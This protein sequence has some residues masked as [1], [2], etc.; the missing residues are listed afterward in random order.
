MTESNRTT[1]PVTLPRWKLTNYCRKE[2]NPIG[3]MNGGHFERH[4]GGPWMLVSDVLPLL[5]ELQRLRSPGG[6]GTEP[7]WLRKELADLREHLRDTIGND[8]ARMVEDIE[9]RLS[10][11][12]SEIQ[13]DDHPTPKTGTCGHPALFTWNYLGYKRVAEC[14]YCSRDLAKRHLSEVATELR[15]TRAASSGEPCGEWQSIETAPDEDAL[16]LC[17]GFPVDTK[18]YGTSRWH[19]VAVYR[20]GQFFDDNDGEL[21][22]DPTHW[23]PCP[24]L[25]KSEKP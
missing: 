4:A 23:M 5:E 1:D 7:G 9:R 24:T 16:V 13:G 20:D 18:N 15:D 22:A 10:G 2:C 6:A 12:P 3:D 11:E 17:T 8:Y 19:S 14:L 25:T 21:M